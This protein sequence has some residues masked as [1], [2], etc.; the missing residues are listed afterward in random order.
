MHYAAGFLISRV[1]IALHLAKTGETEWRSHPYIT[2]RAI[3]ELN[4]PIPKKGSVE[5]KIA[6]EIASISKSLHKKGRD[7]ALEIRLDQLVCQIIGG[8]SDLL[9][10]SYKFLADVKGCSYTR[11]LVKDISLELCVA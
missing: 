6:K 1:V 3:R 9:N 7:T 8:T 5:E 4:L 2:Q 11:D 10:W